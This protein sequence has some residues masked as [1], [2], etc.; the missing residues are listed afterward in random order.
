MWKEFIL[1]EFRVV[2]KVYDGA[3]QWG[4]SQFPRIS[5]MGIWQNGK[6]LFNYDRGLDFSNIPDWLLEAIVKAVSKLLLVIN[7]I[8]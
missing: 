5:K 8:L 7:L 3:S 2:V 6:Q 1:W 4:L